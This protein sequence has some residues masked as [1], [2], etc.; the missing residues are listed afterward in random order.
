MNQMP[1]MQER[2]GLERGDQHFQ[3]FIRVQSAMA[4][5]LG[6][7][8]VG[9]FHDD[10]HILLF[11]ESKSPRLEQAHQAWMIERGGAAP[12]IEQRFRRPAVEAH[13]LDR[14]IREASCLMFGK[15]DCA[16]AGGAQQAA[17]GKSAIDELAR[18]FRPEPGI[19][20]FQFRVHLRIF[21]AGADWILIHAT[22][23]AFAIA[24]GRP[25]INMSAEPCRA[26]AELVRSVIVE[27]PA[28]PMWGATQHL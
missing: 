4:Q 9:I 13:E 17:Q 1:P 19:G 10:E 7:C 15:E 14:G 6:E 11:R 24:P 27:V 8:L 5:D 3:Q 25:K 28:P 21:G 22:L 26:S 20:V 12:L 2:H 18:P 23:P 16:T